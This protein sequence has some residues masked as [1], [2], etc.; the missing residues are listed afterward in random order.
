MCFCIAKIPEF[1]R[2]SNFEG[3]IIIYLPFALKTYRAKFFREQ[4]TDLEKIK[5]YEC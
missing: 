2:K 4:L 5:L 3:Y 1:S